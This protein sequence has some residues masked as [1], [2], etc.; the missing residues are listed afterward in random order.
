MSISCAL[1]LDKNLPPVFVDSIAQQV[2]RGPVLAYFLSLNAYSVSS[3][4]RSL[5]YQSLLCI[6]RRC[7]A[8]FV[9]DTVRLTFSVYQTFFYFSVVTWIIVTEFGSCK[10]CEIAIRYVKSCYPYSHA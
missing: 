1:K 4:Q 2:D 8:G 7:Y 3:L 6:V 10:D 9:D 5:S